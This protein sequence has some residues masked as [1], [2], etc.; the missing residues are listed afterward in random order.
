[1]FFQKENLEMAC[2]EVLFGDFVYSDGR[3]DN[4]HLSIDVQ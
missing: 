4:I 3:L 1:M 2:D